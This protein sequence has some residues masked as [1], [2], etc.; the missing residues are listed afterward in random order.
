MK[1]T[2]KMSVGKLIQLILK[3][4]G[5]S[6]A[7]LARRMGLS[8]PTIDRIIHGDNCDYA[9]ILRLE[10]VLDYPFL[11][12]FSRLDDS[13]HPDSLHLA[14]EPQNSD[15]YY[16]K[17]ILEREKRMFWQDQ[18]LRKDRENRIL[19]AKYERLLKKLG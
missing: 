4:R 7:E 3:K 5:M 19:K 13:V 18:C 12:D 11:K 1:F 6:K 2:Y 9:R 17:F 10:E 15:S 14:F 8:R 16:G